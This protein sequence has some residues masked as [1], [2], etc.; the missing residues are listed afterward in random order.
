MPES[1]PPYSNSR[2]HLFDELRRI[3]LL[4]KRAVTIVR[5]VPPSQ[6][7]AAASAFEGTADA[8]VESSDLLSEPWLY[9]DDTGARLQQI[10]G[11]IQSERA[12]IDARVEASDAAGVRLSLPRLAALAGLWN[13]HVDLLLVL[14]LPD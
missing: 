5:A 10:D 11:E 12:A 9:D 3:D 8:I 2:E 4:F 7:A 6:T 13:T 14:A 1:P